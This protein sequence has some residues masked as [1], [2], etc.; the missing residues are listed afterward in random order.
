MR[1]S[2]S[3]EMRPDPLHCIQRNSTVALIQE[4]SLDFLDGTPDSPQENSHISR[5]MLGS[6]SNTKELCVPQFNLR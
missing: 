1:L 3:H 6:P 5:G 2:P 4:R